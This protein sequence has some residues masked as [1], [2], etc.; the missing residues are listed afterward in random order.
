MKS[1]F[2]WPNPTDLGGIE[3]VARVFRCVPRRYFMP[4]M[5]IYGWGAC[6][7]FAILLVGIPCWG[8]YE[9]LLEKS[10]LWSILTAVIATVFLAWVIGFAIRLPKVLSRLYPAV[11]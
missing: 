5:Q 10:M 4:L 8:S 7:F 3:A 6:I 2:L 11:R 1:A 9:F